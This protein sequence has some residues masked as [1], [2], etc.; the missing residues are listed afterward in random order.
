MVE[1]DQG[2]KLALAGATL[3]F[4]AAAAY[5]ILGGGKKP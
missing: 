2:Q 4:A 1:M 5:F 3:V